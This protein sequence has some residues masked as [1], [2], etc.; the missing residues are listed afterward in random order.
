MWKVTLASSHWYLQAN[1]AFTFQQQ[2]N[3]R[4]TEMFQGS[5]VGCGALGAIIKL[6]GLKT[7]ETELL[8]DV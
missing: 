8:E 2:R 5:L 1:A 3:V 6:E 7:Q 4:F